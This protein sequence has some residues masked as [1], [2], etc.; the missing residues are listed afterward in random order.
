MSDRHLKHEIVRV[1][2]RAPR[3]AVG[4]LLLLGC[5]SVAESANERTAKESAHLWVD[6][7]AFWSQ[8]NN[9]PVCWETSANSFP[10]QRGWVQSALAQTWE[11]VSNVQL[12]GWGTCTSGQAGI[13]IGVADVGPNTSQIGNNLN[14]VTSGVTLNF[15]F[16]SWNP[17]FPLYPLPGDTTPPFHCSDSTA[18]RQKCV[19]VIAVHE[20]GHALGFYHDQDRLDATS[21]CEQANKT[22]ETANGLAI[23]AVDDQSIMSYCS[24]VRNDIIW[25]FTFSPGDMQGIQAIYGAPATSFVG[26]NGLCLDVPNG[27]YNFGVK[28]D[29]FPCHANGHS[30]QSWSFALRGNSTLTSQGWCYDDPAGNLNDGTDPALWSCNGGSNQSWS[31]GNTLFPSFQIQGLGG[32]CLDVQGSIV[33]GAPVVYNTCNGSNSQFWAYQYSSGALVNMGV[34]IQNPLCLDLVQANTNNGEILDVWPCTGNPNQVWNIQSGVSG[35]LRSGLNNN[36]C[37]DLRSASTNN[38]TA[39]EIWDCHGGIN[40]RWAFAGQVMTGP[41]GNGKCLDIPGGNTSLAPELWDCNGGSNQQ[42]VYYP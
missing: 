35:N 14:G 1:S 40:Q 24:S 27:T 37:V 7:A 20:F 30:N 3:V 32:K 13:H 6:S 39:I 19:S 10:T 16:S 34:N 33:A 23:G 9:I 31:F 12:T 21:S 42:W 4:A 15:T 28:P 22:G 2:L 11:A 38:G 8:A 26:E 18:Q 36:K 17:Q 29:L 41:S 5:G 25:P